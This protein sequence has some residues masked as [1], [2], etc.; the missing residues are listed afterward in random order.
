MSKYKTS[1]RSGHYK[2]NKSENS[3]TG[4]RENISQKFKTKIFS[5]KSYLPMLKKK[6]TMKI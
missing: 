1:R 6:V 4:R 2:K 3:R 5:K